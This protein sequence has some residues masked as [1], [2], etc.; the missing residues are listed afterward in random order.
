MPVPGLTQAPGGRTPR[1]SIEF[2]AAN[3]R[4][5]NTGGVFASGL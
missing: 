3:I 5:K 2:F 4:N 1:R